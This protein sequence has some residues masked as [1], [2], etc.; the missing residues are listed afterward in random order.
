[1]GDSTNGFTQSDDS[2]LI[3]DYLVRKNGYIQNR[4]YNSLDEVSKTQNEVSK[5]RGGDDATMSAN[6]FHANND[7][8]N[9]WDDF[10][11]FQDDVIQTNGIT[12]SSVASANQDI[13]WLPDKVTWLQDEKEATFDHH[14]NLD[15]ETESENL[16]ESEVS[17]ICDQTRSDNFAELLEAFFNKE[18]NKIQSVSEGNI[19]DGTT[20]L[21]PENGEYEH[22]SKGSTEDVFE[23]VENNGKKQNIE[24][25]V[26][27]FNQIR[28]ND[29]DKRIATM[30]SKSASATSS[31]M[32]HMAQNGFNRSSLSK[33]VSSST[34]SYSPQRDR[35]NG[36]TPGCIKCKLEQ[37]ARQW[38]Q[39]QLATCDAS[40]SM[41]DL[42]IDPMH[43]E[44]SMDSPQSLMNSLITATRPGITPHNNGL[45]PTAG[46]GG[47]VHPWQSN[48]YTPDIYA[49]VKQCRGKTFLLKQGKK[50]FLL[51]FPCCKNR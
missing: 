21:K 49:N 14:S 24:D 12:S 10:A 6:G 9:L 41:P 45:T 15:S 44:F 20:H 48:G 47:K 2:L 18:E 4:Y 40:G 38:S 28:S 51:H 37:M 33:S 19:C 25:I 7:V 50:S 8:S 34:S 30:G 11:K 46:S 3:G 35:D 32:K 22:K 27:P 16:S 36:Y 29:S 26:M 31:P 43:M 13:E 42:N 5:S 17:D 39:G 1:M 23:A